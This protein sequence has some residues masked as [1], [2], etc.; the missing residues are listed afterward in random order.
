MQHRHL[1]PNE[2]DLLLDAE[3]GFGVA[4]LR[5][6][7]GECPAC[8]A[9]LAEA[10]VVCDALEALPHFAPRP[11]FAERVLAQVQVVEPWHVAAIDTARRLVPTSR[12]VRL[13][14]AATAAVAATSLSAGAVWLAFRADAALYF[15]SIVADRAR[16]ALVDGAGAIVS[17]TFGAA[18]LD[19]IRSGGLA[20]IA[21][22]TAVMFTAVGGAALGFRALATVSRNRR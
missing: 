1:L 16:A 17:Q 9:E 21:L 3:A 5:A 18:A 13:V 10:R 8:A 7:I 4:P 15:V 19:A 20:G 22:G 11:R 2:F 6:H 14:M 12:P